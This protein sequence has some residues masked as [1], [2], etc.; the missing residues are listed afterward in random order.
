MFSW[1]DGGTYQG[2]WKGGK[3]HGLGV[4]RPRP[5]GRATGKGKEPGGGGRKAAVDSD[6]EGPTVTTPR[7][8][9]VG[10]L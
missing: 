2:F 3:K 8:V 6:G 7:C 1:P 10:V 9:A 5:G 4:L